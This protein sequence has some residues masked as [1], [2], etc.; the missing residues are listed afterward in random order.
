MPRV[1][2]NNLDDIFKYHAPNEEQVERYARI[3][4]ATKAFAR[5]ILEECPD[6]RERS[7]AITDLQ[8]VRMTANMSIALEHVEDA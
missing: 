5:V 6:S 2:L 1:T 4:E 8:L 3:N 7:I